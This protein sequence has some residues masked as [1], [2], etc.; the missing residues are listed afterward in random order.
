M[1]HERKLLRNNLNVTD[2][3]RKLWKFLMHDG[4]PQRQWRCTQLDYVRFF[5]GCHIT[6][7]P[8]E[9][10]LVDREDVVVEGWND[11]SK[12]DL[13]MEWA[14]FHNAVFEVIGAS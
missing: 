2:S 10:A 14:Y 13:V 6:L 11:D 8:E 12:G 9:M 3:I 1:L 4:R 7:S 5:V